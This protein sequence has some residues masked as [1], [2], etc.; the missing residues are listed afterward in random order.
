MDK[1]DKILTELAGFRGE[2]TE[3]KGNMERRLA[4][5][6]EGNGKIL[7]QVNGM[8]LNCVTQIAEIANNRK[9]I[10]EHKDDHKDG[11]TVKEKWAIVGS[12][13]LQ[14]LLRLKILPNGG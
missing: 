9:D 10:D 3:Y 6:E 11:A 2:F 14:I 12:Y 8:K 5:V 13:I 7:E 4:N 1:V